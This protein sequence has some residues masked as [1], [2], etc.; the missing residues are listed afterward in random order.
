[1]TLGT[2]RADRLRPAG[3]RRRLDRAHDAAQPGR[4]PAGVLDRRHPVPARRSR[5]PDRARHG[6]A[7]RRRL[8]RCAGRA[9]ASDR[10]GGGEPRPVG[11]A[12]VAVPELPVTGRTRRCSDP[13]RTGSSTSRRTC[14]PRTS[15]PRPR[16]GSTRSSWSS[17]S[18]P[19]RWVRRRAS[20]RRSTSSPCS[21]RPTARRSRAP[22][23]TVWRPPYA[24]ITLGALAGRRF[25]PVRYSPMQPWHDAHGAR[26]LVAGDW[27]RPDHYGD[28]EAEVRNVRAHVGI[29][30]VTPIGQARPARSRRRRSCSTCCTSTGGASSPWEPSG[31]A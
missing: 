28:P 2:R 26:P 25:E 24:P 23:T 14:R 5:P 11:G 10:P 15:S 13:A 22:G 9:R 12:S 20:S 30:D 29:I 8:A 18:R 19:R 27:I 7:G 4:R 3:H 16:R 31:T 17:G 1:M 21:P 6:R